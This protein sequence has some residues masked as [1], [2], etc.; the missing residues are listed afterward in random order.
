MWQPTTDG[1]SGRLPKQS[2]RKPA[3]QINKK[4]EPM[5]LFLQEEHPSY[6]LFP[7]E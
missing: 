1:L 4:I 7:Q 3:A 6:P 5:A 2:E